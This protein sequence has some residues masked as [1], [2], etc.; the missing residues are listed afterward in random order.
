MADFKSKLNSKGKP[1]EDHY[2]AKRDRELI[3]ALRAKRLHEVVKCKT[4]ANKEAAAKYE[5]KFKKIKKK[6]KDKPGKLL[7]ACKELVD[8]ILERCSKK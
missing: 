3:E 8:D 4:D 2:F 5:K 6:H 7:V 1:Q